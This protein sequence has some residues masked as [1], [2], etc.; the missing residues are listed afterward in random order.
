MQDP[1]PVRVIA[2]HKETSIVRGPDGVDRSATV[3]GRFRFEALAP[4]DYPAVGDWVTLAA[5]DA[6]SPDITVITSEEPLRVTIS[7]GAALVIDAVANHSAV[8]V[9]D[10]DW[11]PTTNDRDSRLTATLGRGGARAVLRN[12]GG[13][14]VISRRK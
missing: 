4:S 8:K 3:A 12:S 5:G 11:A 9:A 7:G 14:I 10:F 2:V 13:D 6:A 1:V